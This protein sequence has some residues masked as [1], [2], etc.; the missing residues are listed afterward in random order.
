[1]AQQNVGLSTFFFHYI[2]CPV[3][4]HQLAQQ[5]TETLN[6]PSYN[7]IMLSLA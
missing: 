3:A 4:C 6:S 7:A 5:L 2:Y 1:M